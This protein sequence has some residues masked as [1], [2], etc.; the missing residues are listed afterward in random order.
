MDDETLRNGED[1]RGD[2]RYMDAARL[3]RTSWRIAL[4]GAEV[5][6]IV[7]LRGVMTDERRATRRIADEIALRYDRLDLS[8][9]GVTE[10]LDLRR[11]LF[12][13]GD[14]LDEVGDVLAAILVTTNALI[15]KPYTL[16]DIAV[17]LLEHGPERCLHSLERR[18]ARLPMVAW[19]LV[20]RHRSWAPHR[21]RRLVRALTRLLV[22]IL[23]TP[24]K[25]IH[26]F[27][28]CG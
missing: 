13:P 12:A 26:L 10:L 24:P 25:P 9:L 22:Q 18:D 3:H 2:R 21:Q 4:G 28:S 11:A 19:A 27:Y 5:P 15:N 1:H 17:F 20:D 23:A 8:K 16:R 14:S 6:S 7:D